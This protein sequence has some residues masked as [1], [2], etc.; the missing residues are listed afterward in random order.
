MTDTQVSL[1]EVDLQVSVLDLP[2]SPIS[3][4]HYWISHDPFP[5]FYSI[6]FP[7]APCSMPFL[8]YRCGTLVS[9]FMSLDLDKATDADIQAFLK[10]SILTIADGV[11]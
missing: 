6:S 7:I 8:P 3:N 1:L 5:V 11:L 9:R 2:K 4:S 10:D